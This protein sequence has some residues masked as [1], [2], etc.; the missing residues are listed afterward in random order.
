MIHTTTTE[1]AL[2]SGPRKFKDWGESAA[3]KELAQIHF[4]EN[5]DPVDSINITKN[6]Q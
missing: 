3:T 4:L 1:Y 6:Q 5:F 2:K